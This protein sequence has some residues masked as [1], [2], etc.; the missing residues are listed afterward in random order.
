MPG[1]VYIFSKYNLDDSFIV[2]EK[3]FKY[4]GKTDNVLRATLDDENTEIII[5]KDDD[6]E[7]KLYIE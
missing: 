4:M 6:E 3:E 1:R 5:L 2:A 7:F